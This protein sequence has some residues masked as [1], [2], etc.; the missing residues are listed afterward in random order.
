MFSVMTERANVLDSMIRAQIKQTQYNN[1]RLKEMNTAMNML[2]AHSGGLENF[3]DDK[4]IFKLDALDI[5]KPLALDPD[6]KTIPNVNNMAV[7]GAGIELTSTRLG[8]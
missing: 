4:T 1:A 3:S 8:F 7:V 2:N 5:N 6:G